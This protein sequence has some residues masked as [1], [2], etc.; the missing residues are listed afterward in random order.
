MDT[1]EYLSMLRELTEE[2][3]EVGFRITGSSMNPFLV[4]LRDTAIF[5]KPDRTSLFSRKDGCGHPGRAAS[6]D[7]DILTVSVRC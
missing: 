6:Y 2:G 1:G 4:H 3:R 7:Q 5:K